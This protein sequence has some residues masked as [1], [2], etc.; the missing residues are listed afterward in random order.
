MCGSVRDKEIPRRKRKITSREDRTPVRL[1]LSNRSNT[2]PALRASL[3]T[4][5]GINLSTSMVKRRL[6]E[7]GLNDCVARYKPLLTADHKKRRLQY[8]KQRFSCTSEVWSKVLWS[9]EYRFFLYQSDGKMYVR[10][11]VGEEYLNACVV[12]TVKHG[13]GGIM[14][15]GC[16]MTQGEGQITLVSG[17]L[18]SSGY[19]DLLENSMIPSTHGLCFR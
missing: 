9:D 15:W 5:F 17:T 12:P 4:S 18:N 1:S 10:R 7:A 19:I 3:H 14:V 6:H 13:G 8:T 2:A 11:R 16:M